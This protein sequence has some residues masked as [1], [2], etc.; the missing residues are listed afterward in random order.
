[1]DNNN[2]NPNTN[3][4]PGSKISKKWLV[5]I[6][7]V[8]VI[9]GGIGGTVYVIFSESHFGF[10][11]A[12]TMDSDIGG[13]VKLTESHIITIGPSKNVTKVEKVE[14]NESKNGTTTPMVTIIEGQFNSTADAN[15]AYKSIFN[16]DP[17]LKNETSD[18]FT[19]VV[20][21]L[22]VYGH[23]GDMVFAF[24]VVGGTPSMYKSVVKSL[25]ASM[26]SI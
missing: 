19:Y 24:S 10:P 4:N 1:M 18:G 23:K 5:V 16:G 17:K 21:S 12:A 25:T 26:S 7:A 6:I 20:T 22:V 3:P 13:G 9:A 8:V 14:Y 15:N 2:S 11:S